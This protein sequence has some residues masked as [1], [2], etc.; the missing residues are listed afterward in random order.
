MTFTRCAVV[1][2]SCFALAG[3]S[4]K[5]GTSTAS[6]RPPPPGETPQAERDD[7]EAERSA[8]PP[9]AGA[10]PSAADEPCGF[11]RHDRPAE[12]KPEKICEAYALASA[13]DPD[14]E[15]SPCNVLHTQAF[16][17]HTVTIF[18]AGPMEG[19]NG[20]QYVLAVTASGGP[21]AWY[22]T[23]LSAEMSRHDHYKV[24]KPRALQ[25]VAGGPPEVV[26][27]YEESFWEGYFPEG[28]VHEVETM[29]MTATS[30]LDLAA[31]PPRW[32]VTVPTLRKNETEFSPDDGASD[33]DPKGK[34]RNTREVTSNVSVTW[35]QGDGT[36]QVSRVDDH[37]A[38]H[39]I[40]NFSVSSPPQRCPAGVHDQATPPP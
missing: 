11:E 12:V 21:G 17:A 1:A 39:P 40:G 16:G 8:A 3:C 24:E 38:Q 28:G 13:D 14:F 2:L 34:H 36:F 25:L 4:K 29:T 26:L 37:P 20:T 31:T 18:A 19:T 10:A 15:G 9:G 35:G 5:G 7:T 27:S 23:V 30:V 22:T 6:D 33:Y 32:L